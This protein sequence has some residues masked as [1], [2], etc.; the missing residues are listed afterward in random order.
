[1]TGHGGPHAQ[2]RLQGML[3]RLLA[4]R[5]GERNRLLFWARLRAGEL[6]ADG[7]LDAHAAVQ[8]LTGAA[9]QIGLAREEG[10]GQPQPPS[11]PGSSA[12]G[13]L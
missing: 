11:D 8:A 6:V 4:A 7:D 13:Q 1:M 10:K 5:C 3:V 12:P 9:T 2:A